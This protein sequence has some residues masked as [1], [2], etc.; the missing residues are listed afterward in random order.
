M[1]LVA[2]FDEAMYVHVGEAKQQLMDALYSFGVRAGVIIRG[3]TTLLGWPGAKLP[4][5]A[6]S[7]KVE[8]GEKVVVPV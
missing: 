2:L 3:D 4:A 1:H 7:G 6:Y 5:G 8:V